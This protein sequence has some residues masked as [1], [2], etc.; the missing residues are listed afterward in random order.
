VAIFTILA[1]NITKRK[2]N[3][4]FVGIASSLTLSN[5]GAEV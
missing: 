4:L 5:R 2:F 3:D 1:E